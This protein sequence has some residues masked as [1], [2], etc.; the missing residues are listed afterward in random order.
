MKHY[1]ARPL[2]VLKK[3]S[4]IG[5]SKDILEEL[6]QKAVDDLAHPLKRDELT[7]VES[8]CLRSGSKGIS[9][10]APLFLLASKFGK[11]TDPRRVALKKQFSD[12]ARELNRINGLLTYLIRHEKP[13]AKKKTTTKRS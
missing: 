6:E 8:F 10:I 5:L 7:R 11:S 4:T 3:F 1:I 9:Q 12:A 13:V 2:K